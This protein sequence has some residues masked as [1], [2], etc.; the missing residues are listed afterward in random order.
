[1]PNIKCADQATKFVSNFNTLQLND[2]PCHET[3]EKQLRF[4]VINY[5]QRLRE[6]YEK[7]ASLTSSRSLNFRP[8]LIRLFMW[9][10]WRDFGVMEKGYSLT[11]IDIL[12]NKSPIMGFENVHYPFEK[13]YFWQFLHALVIIAQQFYV[14]ENHTFDVK[15]GILAS[16]LMKFINEC[17]LVN[18]IHREVLSLFYY[19]VTF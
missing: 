13:I 10:M 15:T 11:D 6:I 19:T 1:M 12:L 18:S 9:Q 7:Y 14:N 2:I 17:M 5:L 3:E 16:A 4:V 8:V